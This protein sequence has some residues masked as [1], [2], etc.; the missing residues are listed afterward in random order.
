MLIAGL[1]GTALL[2]YSM[3]FAAVRA[4]EHRRLLEGDRTLQTNL[5]LAHLWFE[6]GL[7]GDTTVDVN[8][9][10]Y[11]PIERAV[12]MAQAMV[13]TNQG[14]RTSIAILLEPAPRAN[15]TELI[16]QL[17]TWRTLAEQ[18]WANKVQSQSGSQ[19]DT[20]FDL[21]FHD[22][23]D[24]ANQNS[25]SIHEQIR[26]DEQ[27]ITS[28]DIGVILIILS[29]AGFSIAL[30]SRSN[31]AKLRQR[32]DLEE[33]VAERTM[34][35]SAEV[36]ERTKT[37]AALLAEQARVRG[38]L[39]TA[40][41]AIITIDEKGIVQ[42]VNPAFETMFGFHS[43]EIVGKNIS[44][45]MPSP[46]RDAHDGYL[47]DYLRTGVQRIIGAE[48]EVMA[49]KR[50]G[51]KFSIDLS[52]G[53][54]RWSGGRL[55]TGFIRDA[56]ERRE[57]E[58]EL[59]GA[60]DLALASAQLKSEFLA[61]MSH[62]IRTPMNG[63]LGMTDL[64]LDTE[65]TPDQRS[66]AETVQV[67][68]EALLVIINDILD[69]SKIEAGKL[70]FEISDF[71]LR[72]IVEGTVGLLAQQADANG[73]ELLALL[74]PDVP[75]HLRGDSGRLRQV[76]NN[77][78]GNAVK[79]TEHGEVFLR[80][81]IA[82]RIDSRIRLRFEIRDTGIGISPE[83]QKKLFK[84][85]SQAD[86]STTRKF[87]G[88][89]L[90]LAIS[91]KLTEM[92]GG[93]IG[94]QSAPGQ[95]STFWFEIE[96]EEQTAAVDQPEPAS[97]ANLTGLR[98]LIVDDNPTAREVLTLQSKSWGMTSSAT[99]T[100]TE[101]LQ[102]LKDAREDGNPFE[103]AILDH[104]MPETDGPT[105]ARM[106]KADPS[107]RYLP[108]ILLSSLGERL[109]SQALRESGFSK[110]LVK[111]VRSTDLLNCLALVVHAGRIEKLQETSNEP[112]RPIPVQ[113]RDAKILLA[114]DNIIN[115]KVASGQL[116]R[117]G[118]IPECVA[119]GREAVEALERVAYDLIF[120]DCQMPDMDGYEA[121]RHIR[122]LE[123]KTDAGTTKTLQHTYIIAMTANVMEGDREKCLAA[124]MN[125]YVGKP[126]QTAELKAALE[127]WETW[128]QEER[129][130]TAHT[131]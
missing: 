52:V 105:L 41:D 12:S 19:A 71:D 124:G 53:E 28:I 3:Y 92:M 89:G 8:R 101:A 7:H 18:R 50:D 107:T 94:V 72:E 85:F 25:I 5:A 23:L 82:S 121:T 127:R 45:I 98:L 51:T 131:L 109:A 122:L 123:R 120:M 81:C 73:I 58:A 117:L 118:Y 116:A 2:S 42:S 86:A 76:L 79:F 38:I 54:V 68:A 113:P 129:S 119:N 130:A 111:P 128:R 64:L 14:K 39:E 43:S 37:E 70:H 60:R 69:F 115:Q 75:T 56:T 27:F 32:A 33:R 6:E 106:L 24:R 87:G 110:S 99:A 77:L 102:L 57:H 1:C 96:L 66:L 15:L 88:T 4:G 34:R 126:V 83:A 125:D 62:E 67:S 31:L 48:R 44:G 40:V 104:H 20:E 17:R 47:A 90:G 112:P 108:L 63:V 74:E 61:N 95:G 9:D 13:A 49:Q 46:Y 59:A 11:D 93:E 65:L 100:A 114:D 84:V 22:I 97:K 80:V 29:L 55:F 26:R 21:V 10:V 30:I 91:K 78:L 103:V 36:A 16:R 35:L